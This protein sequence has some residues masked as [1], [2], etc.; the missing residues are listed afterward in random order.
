MHPTGMHSCQI[1]FFFPIKTEFLPVVLWWYLWIMY[2]NFGVK[3]NIR[4]D[5]L[6][7]DQLEQMNIKLML[8]SVWKFWQISINSIAKK[9]LIC[10]IK[11]NTLPKIPQ[12]PF[13]FRSILEKID[14]YNFYIYH[15]ITI[16]QICIDWQNGNLGVHMK[17]VNIYLSPKLTELQV[18]WTT[19][20]KRKTQMEPEQFRTHWRYSEARKLKSGL[21]SG[22]VV[23]RGVWPL[24]GAAVG[25]P[26]SGVPLPQLQLGVR[27]TAVGAQPINT[28][29][30]QTTQRQGNATISMATITIFISVSAQGFIYIRTKASLLLMG[31]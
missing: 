26:A 29:K 21:V 24:G 15:P 4:C 5:V 17:I 8:H 3:E 30:T 19:N 9:S 14:I 7:F 25:L 16:W 12:I 1:K 22:S 10:L 11:I 27:E 23:A 13:V 2:D 31:S 20:L 28:G 6:G 18:I